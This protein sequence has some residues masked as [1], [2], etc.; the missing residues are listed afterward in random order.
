MPHL[1]IEDEKGNQKTVSEQ[2]WKLMR[3][4]LGKDDVRKG[5]RLVGPVSE[6]GSTAA[7]PTLAPNR[8]AFVPDMILE[9]AKAVAEENRVLESELISAEPRPASPVPPSA[10]VA[11]V[12]PVASPVA[13]VPAPV[14]EGVKQVMQE[15]ASEVFGNEPTTATETEVPD[16]KADPLHAIE[17][18][19][20]KVAEILASIGITTYAQLANAD[21]GAINTALDAGKMGP[22][23]ALVPS[24]KMKAKALAK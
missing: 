3:S 8:P 2:A 18:L 12:A 11:E 7:R 17:T 23:K 4:A 13:E 14:L 9:R 20:V 10:P 1:I 16:P 19:G 5:F 22:K 21:I 6:K 15:A 24:W